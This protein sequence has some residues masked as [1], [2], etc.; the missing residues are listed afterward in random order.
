MTDI[1]IRPAQASDW[2]NAVPLI[3]SAGPEA[4]DFLFKHPGV[5]TA[6]DFLQAA[7]QRPSGQFSYAHHQVVEISGE[8]VGTMLNYDCKLLH[9]MHWRTVTSVL[10]FFKWRAAKIAKLGGV[11]EKVMPAPASDV[12]MIANLA[13][14]DSSQ[15]LG[16][17]SKLIGFAR[18]QALQA[19]Y[20]GLALDVSIENPAAQRLYERLGFNVVNENPSPTD[21]IPGHRYMEALL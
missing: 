10:S 15:G 17:G 5:C 8:V 19:G 13:V 2:P 11:V 14:A 4:F 21:K 12:L 9:A 18:E 16:L 7:F 3:Y 1:S 20:R 6:Q